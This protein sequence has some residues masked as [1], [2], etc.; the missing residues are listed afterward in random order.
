MYVG[1]QA[2]LSAC[3]SAATTGIVLDDGVSHTAPT[4]DGELINN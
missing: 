2:V 4:Y 3:A 1:I